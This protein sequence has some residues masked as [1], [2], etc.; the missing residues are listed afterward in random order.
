M[1]SVSALESRCESPHQIR[2]NVVDHPSDGS[3]RDSSRI[4]HRDVTTDKCI[5][6][7]SRKVSRSY[8]PP[9]VYTSSS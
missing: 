5:S 8:P 7:G 1:R 6:L 3:D 2:D 9:E 4:T